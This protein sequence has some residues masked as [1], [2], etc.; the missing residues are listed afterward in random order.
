MGCCCHQADGGCNIGLSL[1][2][3]CTALLKTPR[4][5][6]CGAV[7]KLSGLKSLNV[8]LGFCV[9]SYK[10]FLVALAC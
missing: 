6:G 2:G 7:R 9:P 10:A 4:G 5:I 1:S 8:R 3:A